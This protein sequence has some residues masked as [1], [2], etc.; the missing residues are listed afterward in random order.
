LVY[1][2]IVHKAIFFENYLLDNEIESDSSRKLL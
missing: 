1:L 2:L